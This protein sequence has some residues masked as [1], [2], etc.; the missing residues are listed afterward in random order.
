[1][2]QFNK[3]INFFVVPDLRQIQ[4]NSVRNFFEVTLP[5]ELERLETFQVTIQQR[6]ILRLLGSKYC[7]EQPRLD[8]REAVHKSATYS[9]NLY[10]PLHLF[11]TFLAKDIVKDTLF[12]GGIP[13]ISS[14]GT[15]VINGV[16]RCVVSQMLRTP[17]IYYKLNVNGTHIATIICNSGRRLRIEL[18]KE[19]SFSV[20]VTKRYK[21]P[22][23]LWLVCMGLKVANVPSMFPISDDDLLSIIWNIKQK[24]QEVFSHLM[25]RQGNKEQS[26]TPS[27]I[28]QHIFMELYDLGH[29]GR[30]NANQILYEN[31]LAPKQSVLL[32][33]D[34]ILVAERLAKT[35]LST[36]YVD[37]I[38]EL[39][40]KHVKSVG[41]VMSDQLTLFL[42]KLR[43]K[44]KEKVYEISLYDPLPRARQL[45][46]E[47]PLSITFNQFFGSYELSQFLD[48]TNPLSDM[49]HKQK[50]SAL[51]PGGLTPRTATFQARDIHSSQYGRICPV[52]TADGQNAGIVTSFTVSAQI[53]GKGSIQNSAYLINNMFLERSNVSLFSANN[54]KHHKIATGSLLSV[55]QHSYD[56]KMTPTQSQKEFISTSWNQIDLR[57]TFPV[58]YFSVGVTLIP[59]LEHN[60]ATRALMGSHM[61]RQA[62]PLINPE[63]PIIG[64]GL[65]A[66]VALDSGNVV[67]AA[68]D[69]NV[70]SIDGN[71]LTIRYYNNK[72][73]T[74][75][76]QLLSFQRSNYNTCIHQR[77]IIK[78]G[79]FVRQGQLLADGG[80]TVGGELALGKNVLVAYMPWKG[81]NFEDAILISERLVC[82]D[83]Y[84]S[85]HI[86]RYQI[87]TNVT[88]E[89]VERITQ[90]VPHVNPYLLR[91]LD[92]TGIV[93]L[94]AFVNTGDVLVGKLTPQHSVDSRPENK[95][96]EAV[97]GPEVM[98][99]KDSSLKVPQR[100]DGRVIDVK[101]ISRENISLKHSNTI[102][103]YILQKRKIQIGDK[104]AGRHGNKGIVSRILPISE[105][106]YLQ[107]GTPIDMVLSPL[108]VP[109]R[110][111]VGQVLECLLGFAGKYL[112]QHYRIMP[113]DERYERESSRKLVLS[114]LYKA[115]QKMDL[116]WL[117]E[118]NSPGKSRLFDA[119]TGEMFDQAVTI[120][121]AYMLKLIHQVDDKIHARSTGPYALVTQQPLRG[122]AKKGGQRVGEMEV[123]ALEGFGAAHVLQ[124]V[125]LIK[126]DHV[127]ARSGVFN[128]VTAGKM[129][130]EPVG[131]QDSLKLLLQELRC[132]SIKIHHTTISQ[133]NLTVQSTKI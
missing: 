102:H 46:G 109:S 54:D 39:N 27:L 26:E 71:T 65:E 12:L 16:S 68:N 105:M 44:I 55:M 28:W 86:K 131:I 23:V 1:M 101:W 110:M 132:L 91:H 112:D 69:A 4:F 21:M 90:K 34:I 97:F 103:I 79:E 96:L 122:K 30:L 36:P 118:Y 63:K 127:I 107:D 52:E 133:K 48:Q 100:A 99:T 81:Y 130:A 73:D 123:W 124:E 76:I 78:I 18:D 120:G 9:S 42:E 84:T 5:N 35:N 3:N 116:P 119:R 14:S 8:E 19:G 114:E 108:G 74:L 77:P 29:V 57:N 20:R 88:V 11:D 95:L 115:S 60:D 49:A 94:G 113:F 41:E 87:E 121:K 92:K 93:S 82:E 2:F 31:H 70:H 47:T 53:D 117:F 40:N 80:A 33:Q 43:T 24:F 129:I 62:V 51:G 32:P 37:D 56:Q 111:N 83:V 6:F 75:D 61:Q 10:I 59:F 125:L 85:L 25:S 126:S 104:I 7:L 50:L 45:V 67:T 106:P 128:T 89:G 38:D 72:K 17:G 22:I 64:T 13:L 98:Q 15:F 58:D 66:Q